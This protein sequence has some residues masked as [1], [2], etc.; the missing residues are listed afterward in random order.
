MF[1]GIWLRLFKH[2]LLNKGEK[3]I[4]IQLIVHGFL[5]NKPEAERSKEVIEV[6]YSH[7]LTVNQ[8]LK[9]IKIKIE[10]LGLVI[11]DGKD[12]N[13]DFLINHSCQIK[14]IPLLVGG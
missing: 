9:D 12:V 8:L 7:A 13:R 6:E 5:S 2:W 14:L 4:K 3:M 10:F 1:T 11:L